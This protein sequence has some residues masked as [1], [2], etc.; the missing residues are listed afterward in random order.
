MPASSWK[1]EDLVPHRPPMVLIDD[2]ESVD[3]ETSS[4]VSSFTA[5]EQWRGNWFALEYMAQTAA[6]LAGA[7]DKAEDDGAEGHPG[8][9]LGTRRLD[10]GI[11]EFVPGVRY[12]VKA[13]REYVDGDCAA[14]ACEIWEADKESQSPKC[15]AILTAKK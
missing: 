11:A 8:L 10:L 13:V 15:T 5:K 12:F 2:I 14:F 6:A 4:L 9:L 1:V 3:L 7:F